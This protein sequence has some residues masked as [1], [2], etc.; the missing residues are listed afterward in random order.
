VLVSAF[1]FPGGAPERVWRAGLQRAIVP[2]TST[3]LLAELSAVLVRRFH[4]DEARVGRVTR[5]IIR[6]SEV[7]VGTSGPTGA[8]SGAGE[9]VLRDPDDDELLAVARVAGAMFVVTGD[10]DVLDH[11]SLPDGLRALRPADL[12]G[13]L[14]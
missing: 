13:L 8:A 9:P 4:W 5:H 14:A 6:A 3:A 2:V 11:A 12:L 10:R 1:V 7:V